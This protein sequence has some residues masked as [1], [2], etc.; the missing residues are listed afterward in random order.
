MMTVKELISELK[1][2]PPDCIV[3]FQDHDAEEYMVSSW[4]NQVI[5][6][7][8]NDIPKDMERDNLWGIE[9]EIVVLHH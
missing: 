8:Y 9:G 7:D 2:M 3:G 5:L 6:L 4:I 1:R